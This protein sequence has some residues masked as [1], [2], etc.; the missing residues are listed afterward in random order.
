MSAGLA[1]QDAQMMAAFDGVYLV[2][3]DTD[4]WG[5]GVPEAGFDFAAI[6]V[7]FR[8]D[9]DGNPTGD[10]IDG[11]A[12]GPDTYENIANTMGPWFHQP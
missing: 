10:W 3:L 9:A 2:Q 7:F 4:E 5:W 6:P 1:E 11:G 8:L 12:W